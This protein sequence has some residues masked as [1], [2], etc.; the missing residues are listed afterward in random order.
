[1]DTT[2]LEDLEQLVALPGWRR[3]AS[4]VKQT[5]AQFVANI[6]VSVSGLAP[7]TDEELAR[8]TR[9][10]VEHR[11]TIDYVLDWPEQRIRKLRRIIEK[12]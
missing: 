4:S 10:S 8:K 12:R 9:A 11:E 5:D 3:F 6:M 2:E 7:H 1:M